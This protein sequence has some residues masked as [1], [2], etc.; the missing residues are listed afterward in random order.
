M[1]EGQNVYKHSFRSTNFWMKKH[2]VYCQFVTNLF[3]VL[4][5]QIYLFSICQKMIYQII[6]G[7]LNECKS[8]YIHFCPLF[9]IHLSRFFHFVLE[10]FVGFIIKKNL[11]VTFIY[12]NSNQLIST[13][14]FDS[15]FSSIFSVPG[16][17]NSSIIALYKFFYTIRPRKIKIKKA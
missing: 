4:P 16:Q 14:S 11:S 17:G 12:S 9:F 2:L 5:H 10:W 3:Q 8:F 7:P 13:H 15:N 6:L 1:W